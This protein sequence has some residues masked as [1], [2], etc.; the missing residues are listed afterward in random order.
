MAASGMKGN[1]DIAQ[2]SSWLR[3]RQHLRH[4]R[5]VL[6][7]APHAP[8][9]GQKISNPRRDLRRAVCRDF[10]TNAFDHRGFDF[11]G[12]KTPWT[13]LAAGPRKVP[14]LLPTSTSHQPVLIRQVCTRSRRPR[15][16][17][18]P[19][20]FRRACCSRGSSRVWLTNQGVSC[21]HWQSVGFYAC[22]N[23]ATSSFRQ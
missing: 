12:V 4:H 11:N 17:N 6:A 21:R 1:A 19:G 22:R 2:E 18:D 13:C 15:R 23:L 16:R 8:L 20:T 3:R 9:I 5:V 7:I 10:H 14:K